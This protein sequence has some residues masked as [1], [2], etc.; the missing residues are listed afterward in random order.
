VEDAPQVPEVVPL[1]SGWHLFV[2]AFHPQ[3]LFDWQLVVSL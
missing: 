1:H 2:S 3:A